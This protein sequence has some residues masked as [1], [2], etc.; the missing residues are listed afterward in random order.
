RRALAAPSSRGWRLSTA[1]RKFRGRH[2]LTVILSFRRIRDPSA[3]HDKLRIL[4][5]RSQARFAQDDI[6]LRRIRDPSARRD[7]LRILRL[8]SQARFAQDDT[9]LR[10]RGR[11]GAGL[12]GVAKREASYGPKSGPK[13]GSR[14]S[15]PGEQAA[16][17]DYRKTRAL[18]SARYWPKKLVSWVQLVRWAREEVSRR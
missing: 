16:A 8:R 10:N 18:G 3:R 11:P 6:S 17:C 5:L 1:S 13:A 15:S 9:A 7:R 14:A 2:R 4:R 12:A